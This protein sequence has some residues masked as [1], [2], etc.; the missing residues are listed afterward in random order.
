MS[1]FEA[2]A[3]TLYFTMAEWFSKNGG[4]TPTSKAGNKQFMGSGEFAG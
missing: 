3:T 2:M 1:N 4:F